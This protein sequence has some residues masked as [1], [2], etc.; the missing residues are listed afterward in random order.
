M[1]HKSLKTILKSINSSI[2]PVVVPHRHSIEQLPSLLPLRHGLIHQSDEASI[3][4]RLKQ[5]HHFVDDDV[6]ET[7]DRLFGQVCI[8]S[9][10]GCSGIATP[11]S[12]F[13]PLNEKPLD[14]YSQVLFPS[15]DHFWNFGS[16][17]LAIP[18]LQRD[19][20]GATI[21]S[22]SVSYTPLHPPTQ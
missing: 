16:N 12:R 2:F 18:T 4:C 3:V 21:R 20:A 13:H 7:L 6:L 11:P 8:Q 9:N 1:D 19:Q 10:A 17:L 22:R 14:L 15:L 5:V